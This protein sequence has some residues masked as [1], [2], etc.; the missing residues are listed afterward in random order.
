[1]PLFEL[2]G[3]ITQTGGMNYALARENKENYSG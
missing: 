2:K 3:M 1:M